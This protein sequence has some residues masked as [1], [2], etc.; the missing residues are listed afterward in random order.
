MTSLPDKADLVRALQDVIPN[1]HISQ[2]D[3]LAQILAGERG[4][5]SPHLSE[6]GLGEILRGLAGSTLNL[7]NSTVQ[8]GTGNQFGDVTIRD[9][10][11]HDILHV[12]V[13]QTI[14]TAEQAY[15]VGG[16]T[17]PYLGLR[18]FTYADR[19]RFAGRGG[20][21]AD[22]VKLLTVPSEE[23]ALL[24]IT[25]ASGSGKSSLVQ[26]GIIPALEG[27][28]TTRSKPFQYA[29]MRPS[30]QPLVALAEAL[31]QLG[32]PASGPFAA[33]APYTREA[34]PTSQ[35]LGIRVLVIDQMEELF[36]QSEPDQ[37]EALL[38]M[39][40]ALPPFHKVRVHIIGTL[41]SDFLGE[42]ADYPAL[43]SAFREQLLV[44]VMDGTEL[45]AAIQRPIQEAH[46]QKRI[47]PALLERLTTDAA[48]DAAYLPLLQVTLEDLWQRGSLTLSAYGT[49]TD[50]IRERA[51]VVYHYQDYD[52]ARQRVRSA[53]EQETIM[54]LLLDLIEIGPDDDSRRD[55]R[56]R[57]DLAKLT[58]GMP[59][60]TR[61]IDDLATARL[62]SKGI[63]Q[64]A[65]A[66][67]EVVDIIHESLIANWQ[68]FQT[69]IAE[70][71][72]ALQRRSRFEAALRLWVAR[73]K[74][75]DRIRALQQ[76]RETALAPHP[77]PAVPTPVESEARR[78]APQIADVQAHFGGDLS[79][80]VR[81]RR[82]QRIPVGHIAPDVRQ[83]M[84]QPRLLP[85]PDEIMPAGVPAPIYAILAAELLDLGRS[86]RERQIQPI[87]VYAGVNSTYPAARYLILVG[88]RRW[89]AACLVGMES[90]DAIVVDV[91][92]PTERIRIQYAENEDRE[93]FSD[94]E[95]A[96]ALQ[97]MKAA[98]G[99]APWEDV[100][101]RLQI[102][103]TRRHQLIRLLAFTPEQQQ[104]VAR[105]RLQETQI[106]PLHMAARNL[107]LSE[108]QV[109]GVLRR[110][111]EI[112]AERTARPVS[113][114]ADA[115]NA[116][117]Q[118]EGVDGPTVAR[119]VARA[120]RNSATVPATPRWL[121]LLQEQ[122]ERTRQALQR[123]GKRADML[124]DDNA[125]SLIEAITL[126]RAESDQML[127]RLLGGTPVTLTQ[128]VSEEF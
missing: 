90:L 56:Q 32:L 83:E 26:A 6:D 25:G 46:P 2:L 54:A 77:S 31:R 38:R 3:V 99:D 68:R 11:G 48:G 122:L 102:S 101:A 59:A 126:L 61:L 16:L 97:H 114:E 84:R 62:V 9:I 5:T 82:V 67:V 66:E 29:V 110:L 33:A 64:R 115:T 117:P 37:R 78:E 95:R 103:R 39:L 55:V 105:I 1:A 47:E 70:R 52:G 58:Q 74:P 80:L 21:I 73:G 107:E 24:F 125:T 43:E 76:Q 124:G 7:S 40:G 81:D 111:A 15:H 18:A 4:L 87:I 96:W 14:I 57:R 72:E 79:Q 100:E 44:R 92:T 123:A 50:A 113:D 128:P 20:L 30:R 19:H 23:R 65:G 35:R 60:R 28:Y 109:N 85:T 121:P 118:R 116:A 17:N 22:A 51:E 34:I 86:L 41:R 106:R 49:L 120:K 98:I 27:H 112:A 10:A 36:T 88:Q 91:P 108:L 94:M 45:K 42:L 75:D 93:E 63:E 53:D 8:F 69:V 71:R 12:N 119:L 13:A 127:E 104:V 89:T